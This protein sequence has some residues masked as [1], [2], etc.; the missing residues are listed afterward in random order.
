LGV[1]VELDVEV[2]AGSAVG[3]FNSGAGLPIAVALAIKPISVGTGVGV[4]SGAR[5]GKLQAKTATIRSRMGRR[6]LK[7]LA[8]LM[9]SSFLST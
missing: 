2:A 7:H 1:L 4:A 6:I 8:A 3:V 9:F 5:L